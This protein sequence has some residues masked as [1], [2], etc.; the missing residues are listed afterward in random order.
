[1]WIR[2]GLAML[3]VCLAIFLGNLV[4]E[5]MGNNQTSPLSTPAS[6]SESA[7]SIIQGFQYRQTKAGVVEWEVEAQKAKILESQH[8]ADLKEVKVR[9]YRDGGKEMTLIAQEGTI[10]TE[11][12]N[13]HLENRGDPI[14]VELKSGYTI[15]SPRLQWVNERQEIRSTDSVLIQGNGLNITGH[16]LI[17]H[18]R[19][20]EFTILENVHV[21]VSS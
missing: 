20:E 5:R 14:K 10:N 11:T 7:D 2:R 3:V 13:F 16:G 17:G 18:L 8:Q 6:F 19:E 21:E 12:H 1:M 15:Y 4:V 9:L